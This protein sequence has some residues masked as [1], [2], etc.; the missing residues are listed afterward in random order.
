M[1]YAPAVGSRRH[2]IHHAS[3]M[4]A[5]TLLSRVTGYVRDKTLAYVLGA[6]DFYDAFLVAFTIP[7]TFRAL[8]AE[9]ALHAAFIPSLAG[10]LAEE[11]RAEARRLVRAMVATML[12]LLVAVV[13]LGIAASPVLV[14]AFGA[15]FVTRPGQ[16]E[17]AV[18]MNRLMFPYLA[19]ISLA[20]LC[21]GVLNSHDRF[22]LP[23]ASPILLNAALVTAGVVVARGTS[24][25]EVVL[26]L[27]VLAGGLGQLAVQVVVLPRLGYAPWPEW[28]RAFSPEVRRVLLLM[29]PGIPVLGINQLNQLVSRTFASLTGSGGVT[30]T[31]NAY[32]ITEL[33]FGVV[34][35]QLTTVLLPALARDVGRDEAAA[36][37]TLGE[38][39]R[40]VGFVTLPSVAVLAVAARP[41]VGLLFGGGRYTAAQVAVTG[42]TL[43]AYAFGLVGLATVKVIASAFYARRDTRTPAIGAGLS[44]AVFAALCSVLAPRLG[45]PGIGWANAVAVSCY[46]LVLVALYAVRHGFGRVGWVLGSLARQT[47]GAVAAGGVLV[48]LGGWLAAVHATGPGAALRVGVALA[49]AGG[50]YVGLVAAMGGSEPAAVW[51]TLAGRGGGEA[52]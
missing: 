7:N 46:A 41:I 47:V 37:R 20:A 43:R 39:L 52:R 48:A 29:L 49:A 26:A 32:R 18:F 2:L 44:L 21:Q 25:P 50:V 34:V 19:L 24:R 38:A 35:V 51:R 45:P 1:G 9:G 4:S 6:G 42:A 22:L 11:R 28:R 27:G 15:G 13:G 14:R 10:L 8:L 23:A 40:L 33:V 5:V 16:V 17:L 30:Y 36:R 3:R 12:P 31:Y